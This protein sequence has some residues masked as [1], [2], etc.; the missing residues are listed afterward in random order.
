MKH[1]TA[2]V[3]LLLSACVNQLGQMS[4]KMMNVQLGMDEEELILVMG[5]P[6]SVSALENVKIY[7]YKL[8]TTTST[9]VMDGTP[10]DFYVIF[11]DGVVSA[12]GGTGALSALQDN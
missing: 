2:L 7:N 9:A 3:F 4:S 6:T 1:I 10:E 12:Y 8:Y 11:R 5:N